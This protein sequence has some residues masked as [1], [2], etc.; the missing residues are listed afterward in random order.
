MDRDEEEEENSFSQSH[1]QLMDFLAKGR[2]ERKKGVLLRGSSFLPNNNNKALD[3]VELDLG[4][5]SLSRL[6]PLSF[7]LSCWVNLIYGVGQLSAVWSK[8]KKKNLFFFRKKE[9][10]KEKQVSTLVITGCTVRTAI[11]KAA[12]FITKTSWLVSSTALWGLACGKTSFLF[13]FFFSFSISQ[14]LAAWYNTRKESRE[15]HN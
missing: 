5:R 3:L 4:R 15:R 2:R 7:P 13:F 14:H 8:K 10:K 9:R 11:V 1:K 6:A 12:G